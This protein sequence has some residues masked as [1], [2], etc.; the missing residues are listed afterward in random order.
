MTRVNITRR[1]QDGTKYV[2]CDEAEKRIL[3]SSQDRIKIKTRPRLLSFTATNQKKK[4]FQPLIVREWGPY[5]IIM[6]YDKRV[7]TIFDHYE[8]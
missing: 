4:E 3:F 8:L 1:E 6:N 5:L 7:G 2:C